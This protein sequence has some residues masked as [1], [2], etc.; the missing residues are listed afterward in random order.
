MRRGHPCSL[1]TASPRTSER[2][3]K[4][5]MN[6]S[7]ELF[8]N[9]RRTDTLGMVW[10]PCTAPLGKTPAMATTGGPAAGVSLSPLVFEILK[11]RQKARNRN[12]LV[13][14]IRL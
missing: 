14:N 6:R 5:F 11:G 9:L 4:K 13:R 7:D 1:F 8:G 10:H 2:L 12:L 3:G